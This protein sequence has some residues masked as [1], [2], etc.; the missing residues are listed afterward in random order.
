MIWAAW[1]DVVFRKRRYAIAIAATA[2]VFALSLLL[3]GVSASFGREADRTLADVGAD[4]GWSGTGR[5]GRSPRSCRC[6]RPG[7]INSGGGVMNARPD[8]R[9]PSRRATGHPR[10]REIAD[11]PFRDVTLFGV[12]P[13]GPGAPRIVDGHGIEGSSDAVVDRSLGYALGD[14]FDIGPRS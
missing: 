5:P 9:D 3:S 11:A 2:L 8:G 6:G 4:A 13:A 12:D 1:R 10:G 14:Q 7:P